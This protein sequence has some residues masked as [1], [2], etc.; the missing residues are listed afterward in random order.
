V[1]SDRQPVLADDANADPFFPRRRTLAQAFEQNVVTPVDQ[2][3]DQHQDRQNPRRAPGPALRG[4]EQRSERDDGTAGIKRQGDDDDQQDVKNKIDY[5]GGKARAGAGELELES[6]V[7]G[8]GNKNTL[9]HFFS[10][11]SFARGLI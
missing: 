1:Q 6:D 5:V 11:K 2:K 10:V 8:G 4:A 7:I 3:N 9:V